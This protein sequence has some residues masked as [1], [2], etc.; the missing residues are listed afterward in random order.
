VLC[1]TLPGLAPVNDIW[2]A[3]RHPENKL[4]GP[5]NAIGAATSKSLSCS[6]RR[7]AD[8]L[9]RREAKRAR[10]RTPDRE[11][12][13]A[14]TRDVPSA[15]GRLRTC[16][17]ATLLRFQSSR[18][19]RAGACACAA[20]PTVRH[21]NR[22]KPATAPPRPSPCTCLHTVRPGANQP[23]HAPAPICSH[24]ASGPRQSSRPARN[25]VTHA[26]YCARTRNYCVCARALTR[27]RSRVAARA[28]RSAR[29]ERCHGGR[30]YT[31]GVVN[32]PV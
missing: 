10:T 22:K 9:A 8:A 14:A 32:V 29:T 17:A 6:G 15:A 13:A 18:Q 3:H 24:A 1:S 19:L 27:R 4:V 2:G 16:P 31:G 20:A 23:V 11:S 12:R 7:R 28:L 25:A 21:A 30:C 26:L 5:A